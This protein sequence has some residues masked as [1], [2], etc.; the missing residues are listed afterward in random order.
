MLGGGRKKN[1]FLFSRYCSFCC[2]LLSAMPVDHS[3]LHSGLT[4]HNK[5]HKSDVRTLKYWPHELERSRVDHEMGEAG[6]PKLVLS[7]NT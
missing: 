3:K 4:N 2:Q 5:H 7:K 6:A 1:L